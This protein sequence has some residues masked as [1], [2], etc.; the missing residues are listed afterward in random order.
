MNARQ[1]LDEYG[2]A[3]AR[4]VAEAAGTKLIYIQQIAGNHRTPSPEMAYALVK[5]SG[6]R[7][8]MRCLR[9]DLAEMFAESA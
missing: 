6:N 1:F 8:T 4:R 7:M 3:E 2:T 5:A 9:P